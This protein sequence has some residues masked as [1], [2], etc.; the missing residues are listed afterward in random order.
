MVGACLTDGFLRMV[1]VAADEMG[2]V[3]Q[4]AICDSSRLSD[5]SMAQQCNSA[6]QLRTY[7]KL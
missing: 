6:G 2:C 7:R 3:G 1:A 4:S 5:D